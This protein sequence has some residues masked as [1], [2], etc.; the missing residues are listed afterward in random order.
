[1]GGK[2]DA[3][4]ERPR[5]GKAA[6]E[7]RELEAL[8]NATYTL[9]RETEM[10][11][12]VESAAERSG[13]SQR[14]VRRRFDDLDGLYRNVSARLL[15]EVMTMVTFGPPSG[16]LEVD[17]TALVR[18][19]MQIFAHVAPFQRAARVVRHGSSF[20]REQ[21]AFNA[22]ALRAALLVMV[23][24]YLPVES[25]DALDALDVLLSFEA[26]ERLRG[27]QQVTSERAER[28]LASAAVAIVRAEQPDRASK[29]GLP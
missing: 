16:R 14:V 21:E 12:T 3:R 20:L 9:V 11:P 22:N 13:L 7:A 8:A 1:M 5:E 18:R 23:S 25:H 6:R 15:R 17:M 2:G 26:W 28:L 27:P 4:A 10:P 24:P 19:R 29:P